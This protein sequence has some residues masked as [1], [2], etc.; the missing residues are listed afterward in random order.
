MV[1]NSEFSIDELINSGQL[2]PSSSSSDENNNNN[3]RQIFQQADNEQMENTNR[4]S[5]TMDIINDLSRHFQNDTGNNGC[6]Y[7]LGMLIQKMGRGLVSIQEAVSNGA[8]PIILRS[9]QYHKEDTIIIRLGLV[10][11]RKQSTISDGAALLGN[12]E[13]LNLIKEVV[14]PF[15]SVR[16]IATEIINIVNNV[17]ENNKNER[18][19]MAETTMANRSDRK[20]NDNDLYYATL[21]DLLLCIYEKSKGA[22]PI[23]TSILGQMKNILEK[24]MNHQAISDHLQIVMRFS[25][26]LDPIEIDS[27]IFQDSLSILEQLLHAEPGLQARSLDILRKAQA[28][29]S[30]DD[31]T[32]MLDSIKSLTSLTNI[33]KVRDCIIVGDGMV[34]AVLVLPK[35]PTAIR[36]IEH[37]STNKNGMKALASAVFAPRRLRST[38]NDKIAIIVLNHL[39]K[40]NVEEIQTFLPVTVDS[41]I[42][43]VQNLLERGHEDNNNALRTAGLAALAQLPK[44]L[45][46]PRESLSDL[47]VTK[48]A[49]ISLEISMERNERTGACN[50]IQLINSL[51]RSPE[52]LY[53]FEREILSASLVKCLNKFGTSTVNGVATDRTVLSV[54]TGDLQILEAPEIEYQNKLLKTKQVLRSIVDHHTWV[55]NLQDNVNILVQNANVT[56][57]TSA[58][59]AMIQSYALPTI[60]YMISHNVNVNE[61]RACGGALKLVLSIDKAATDLVERSHERQTVKDDNLSKTRAALAEE[62]NKNLTAKTALFQA[63]SRI[64]AL[65]IQTESLLRKTAEREQGW[66]TRIEVLKQ[67]HQDYISGMEAKHAFELAEAAEEVASFAKSSNSTKSFHV[68]MSSKIKADVEKKWKKKIKDM[69]H[70]HL[71]TIEELKEQHKLALESNIFKTS[72]T[73]KRDDKVN[74]TSIELKLELN[75]ANA[76]ISK[77]QEQIATLKDNNER[78]SLHTGNKNSDTEVLRTKHDSMSSE[79]SKNRNKWDW[80]GEETL[81]GFDTGDMS[82]IETIEQKLKTAE[83]ENIKLV[84]QIKIFHNKSADTIKND[85]AD[86]S[87]LKLKYKKLSQLYKNI[88]NEHHELQANLDKRIELQV[89]STVKQYKKAM[90][91]VVQ[92][93]ASSTARDKKVLIK[94]AIERERRKFAMKMEK[95]RDTVTREVFETMKTNAAMEVQDL[96]FQVLEEEIATEKTDGIVKMMRGIHLS[97]QHNVDLEMNLR[98]EAIEKAVIEAKHTMLKNTKGEHEMVLLEQRGQIETRMHE[99]VEKYQEELLALRKDS[100][101]EIAKA[102]GD[103]TELQMKLK[104]ALVTIEVLKQD[105]FSIETWKIEEKRSMKNRIML[106]LEDEHTKLTQL[107][108]EDLM[109]DLER[110]KNDALAQVRIET[111]N[112]LRKEYK[113]DLAK[114]MEAQNILHDLA[115]KA[116]E[117]KVLNY[118]N[119]KIKHQEMTQQFDQE[120][121]LLSANHK[122]KDE[123]IEQLRNKNSTLELEKNNL[124]TLLS[125]KQLHIEKLEDQIRDTLTKV[126]EARRDG[127]KSAQELNDLQ[128]A[129]IKLQNQLAKTERELSRTKISAKALEQENMTVKEQLL[130]SN[131]TAKENENTYEEIRRERN[132]LLDRQSLNTPKLKAYDVL[133][134]NNEATNAKLVETAKKLNYIT[135]EFKL[136]KNSLS[137]ERDDTSYL[138]KE[139]IKMEEALRTSTDMLNTAAHTKVDAEEIHRIMSDAYNTTEHE[140]VSGMARQEQHLQN[141][142]GHPAKQSLKAFPEGRIYGI[143][144]NNWN[145][146]EIK[147]DRDEAVFKLKT[148]NDEENE[149]HLSSSLL[150][151]D[152]AI[153]DQNTSLLQVE[154]PEEE[155]YSNSEEE[156]EIDFIKQATSTFVN[157]SGSYDDNDEISDEVKDNDSF[158][159]NNGMVDRKKS[160]VQNRIKQ[161]DRDAESVSKKQGTS[162]FINNFDKYNNEN[163]ISSEMKVGE[164]QPLKKEKHGGKISLVQSRIEQYDRPLEHDDEDFFIRMENDEEEIVENSKSTTFMTNNLDAAAAVKALHGF[165]NRPNRTPPKLKHIKEQNSKSNSSSGPLRRSAPKSQQYKDGH[166]LRHENIE[167]RNSEQQQEAAGTSGEEEQQSKKIEIERQRSDRS[168]KKENLANRIAAISNKFVE[169]QRVVKPSKFPVDRNNDTFDGLLDSPTERRIIE[170]EVLK[171][172]QQLENGLQSPKK[173]GKTPS[174]KVE[175]INNIKKEEL[176][177]YMHGSNRI[178]SSTKGQK[179]NSI[180]VQPKENPIPSPLPTGM[181]TSTTL[182][183]KDLVESLENM[184]NVSPIITASAVPDDVND[185][186]IERILNMDTEENIEN[187]TINDADLNAQKP[188]WKRT[189][190]KRDTVLPFSSMLSTMSSRHGTGV[191]EVP[192]NVIDRSSPLNEVD[193]TYLIQEIHRFIGQSKKSMNS[194]EEQSHGVRKSKKKKNGKKKKRKKAKKQKRNQPHPVEAH[195]GNRLTPKRHQQQSRRVRQK[196]R[197]P[198]LRNSTSIKE[199]QKTY[200]EQNLA[201]WY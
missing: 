25:S 104:E 176:G 105:E 113:T 30:L 155:F 181:R 47:Q 94:S 34:F 8:L 161:Y 79:G 188:E 134:K 44:D 57:D 63:K 193:S 35:Y 23:L 160:V 165:P 56:N 145:D 37:L 195:Q 74:G 142:R 78:L 101:I 153:F 18:I 42:Q 71:I 92:N 150:Q 88:L 2:S 128:R 129:Q 16:K 91:E 168:I 69:T 31:E 159:L 3:S 200:M 83:D 6:R 123:Q 119:H 55:A 15:L 29:F 186:E 98:E 84:R 151:P 67:H 146:N 32:S 140:T 48:S 53:D 108:I 169:I 177:T 19:I 52:M 85:S 194:N 50:A 33:Y 124:S 14:M 46:F 102:R 127:K 103:V 196:Y 81:K 173:I 125:D 72:E 82:R 64:E 107:A 122:E 97:T 172:E 9:I 62:R 61:A 45:Q 26:L 135:G 7:L 170:A 158:E 138:R 189:L 115:L 70:K 89:E 49:M 166:V 137:M 87:E 143:K 86:G 112:K 167:S 175:K 66:E 180:L 118:D 40:L 187:Q 185:E 182:V 24:H 65:G 12:V 126:V 106:E 100:E 20:Y 13:H 54:M 90:I 183:V 162:N 58:L 93:Q 41:A 130:E 164:R 190:Y 11:L 114:E 76:V 60:E 157:D 201:S 174:P 68:K 133:R 95:M 73:R 199:E 36:L 197:N 51:S 147:E 75:E 80:S 117:R 38:I 144:D 191:R 179:V 27:N 131:E 178:V 59:F 192:D 10:C 5:T 132:T 21:F 28:H 184:G 116:L 154:P 1:D 121:K 39:A 96:L 4:V 77:L 171:Y 148:L 198:L 22:V 163:G 109:K 139:L 152:S 43:A 141:S 111:E 120:L 136:L 149:S 156:S 110:E 99:Q 17:V